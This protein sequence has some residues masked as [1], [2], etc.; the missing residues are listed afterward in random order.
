MNPRQRLAAT[1]DYFR[2]PVLLTRGGI[3]VTV[4][5]IG[6]VAGIAFVI[7]VAAVR[8]LADERS[9]R[10]AAE[11]ARLAERIEAAENDAAAAR[12]LA[13]LESPSEAEVNRRLRE[14]IRAIGANPRLRRALARELSRELGRTE[15]P[16]PPS[17]PDR[18]SVV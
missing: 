6:L 18:K 16:P 1:R 2:A 12:R 14:A 4:V 9:A 10:S 7:S 11:R 3:L 8:G 17:T 15:A 13:A 5:V